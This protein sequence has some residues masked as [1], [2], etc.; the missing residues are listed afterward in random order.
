MRDEPTNWF[1]TIRT[2]QQEYAFCCMSKENAMKKLIEEVDR[3]G[4]GV[5]EAELR[6]PSGTVEK[7]PLA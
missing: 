6:H 2:S 1:L 5:L 7:L 4:G 3:L